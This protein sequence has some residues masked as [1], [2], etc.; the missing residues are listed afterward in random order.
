ML[1]TSNRRASHRVPVQCP[2][3]Y[4]YQPP[5]PQSLDTRVLDL[6][7]DGACVQV[8]D[9]LIPGSAVAF[10]IITS[11]HQVID[12]RAKVVHV[13]SDGSP[14]YRAGVCFVCVSEKDRALLAREIECAQ[15]H[16]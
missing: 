10:V 15:A 2:V 3:K 4:L 9:P 13:R 1:S 16:L 8:P 11:E 5:T 14:L 6:G 12:V 7:L